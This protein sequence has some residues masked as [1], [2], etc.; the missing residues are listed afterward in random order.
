MQDKRKAIYG[1]NG[2]SKLQIQFNLF[3]FRNNINI[4]LTVS[5][6]Q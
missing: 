3:M 4:L 5:N 6:L 2:D 1:D